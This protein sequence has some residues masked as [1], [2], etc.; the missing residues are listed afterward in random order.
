ML[1]MFFIAFLEQYSM[2]WSLKTNI[3]DQYSIEYCSVIKKNEMSFA[4]TYMDL[5]IVIL[6]SS[7]GERQIPCD[8]TY[9]WNLK[10]D[11]NELVYETEADSQAWII[12]LWLPKGREGD[13][14]EF[15]S[16][17]LVAARYY[18]QNE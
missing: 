5:E 14:D 13:R 9:M 7:T 17:E 10:Y 4:V 16:L 6:S 15:G 2:N 8:I 12:D 18:I 1:S 3:L 11:R